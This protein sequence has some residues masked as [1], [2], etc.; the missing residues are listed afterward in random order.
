MALGSRS[1]CMPTTTPMAAA[2]P[3]AGA[4]RTRSTLIASQTSS[5]VRQSRYSTLC[6]QQ[7][8]I[9]Y[10]DMAVGIADPVDGAVG[11]G[12]LIFQ[13]RISADERG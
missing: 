13:P 7:S 12:V 2:T 10:A 8:L 4:P 3:M 5:T 6:G 9:D 11:H 1:V